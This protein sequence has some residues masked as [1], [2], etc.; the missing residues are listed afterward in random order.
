[1]RSTGRNIIV[2]GT[3]PCGY[4]CGTVEVGEPST[5][6]FPPIRLLPNETMLPPE[7]VNSPTVLPTVVNSLIRTTALVPNAIAP[8]VPEFEP[9]CVAREFSMSTC[10][11]TEV[12]NDTKPLLT[13]C[14]TTLFR[15]VTVVLSSARK[16]KLLRSSSGA[17]RFSTRIRSGR[18]RTRFTSCRRVRM[19]W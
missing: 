9:F 10:V 13:L 1:M 2:V 7:A 14:A 11:G 19:P 3:S 16:P 5:I 6:V 12:E 4:C 15:T 17:A 18:R 8:P